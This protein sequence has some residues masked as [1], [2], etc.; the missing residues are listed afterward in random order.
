MNACVGEGIQVR[1]RVAHGATDLDELGTAA[2]DAALLE[3]AGAASQV[4]GSTTRVRVL[5]RC[6]VHVALPCMP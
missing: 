2:S 4:I 3:E 6:S 5:C 1:Q